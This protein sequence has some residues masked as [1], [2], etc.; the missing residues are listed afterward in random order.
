MASAVGAPVMSCE[1][2]RKYQ[3]VAEYPAPRTTD[4]RMEADVPI[5]D[6]RLSW[7]MQTSESPPRTQGKLQ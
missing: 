4:I 2:L 6:G 5:S 7:T 1:F 3:P